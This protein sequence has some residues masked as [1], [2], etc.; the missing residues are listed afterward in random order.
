[1]LTPKQQKFCDEFLIDLNGGKAAE[2]AGYSKKTAYSIASENLKK[3]EIVAYLNQKRSEISTKTGITPERVLQEYA[4]LA[5]FD[6]RNIY[7]ENGNLIS[8][9]SLSDDTAA[10]IAG[11]EVSQEITK[12]EKKTKTVNNTV[13]VKIANKILALDSIAK[14]LGMFEKD[15]AQKQPPPAISLESFTANDLKTLL[16]LKQKATK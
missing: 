1:M 13:K 3:P 15:N 5:F 4:R 9:K 10:A 11:V 2:R 16:A 6:I 14:H 8:I 7:D 12:T